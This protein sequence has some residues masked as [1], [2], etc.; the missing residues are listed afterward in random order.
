[1]ESVFKSVHH[2]RGRSA[3]LVY[4]QALVKPVGVCVTPLMVGAT[5]SALQGDP[6]LGYLV[7]GGPVA[8]IV[9]S[10]WTHFLLSST[11]AELR[12]QSGQVALRSVQDV[13]LDRPPNWDPLYSVRVSPESVEISVRW[14]T[15]EFRQQNWP[16]YN[17]LRERAKNEF[18]QQ[19][20]TESSP[21]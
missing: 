15:Q 1:M 3:E 18:R 10:L 19:G 14:N 13:V 17:Q 2:P 7:W 6:I 8:L 11:P 5:A 20:Q 12:L 16:E 21:Q 4:T 9:A